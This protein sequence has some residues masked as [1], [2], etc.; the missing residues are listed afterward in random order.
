[1]FNAESRDPARE[2]IADFQMRRTS[3]MGPSRGAGPRE[4]GA[5]LD[6]L[7][8]A[9]RD[10]R[11]LPWRFDLSGVRLTEAHLERLRP[12]FW[13]L[14]DSGISGVVRYQLEVLYVVAG[15]RC[16]AARRFLREVIDAQPRP[17]DKASKRRRTA[18]VAAIAALADET[19]DA[20]MF[21]ELLGL[22]EHPRDEVR[23]AAARGL[24]TLAMEEGRGVPV[25]IVAPVLRRAV[26]A[27]KK[28]AVRFQA[29]AALEMMGAEGAAAPADTAYELEVRLAGDRE[30]TVRLAAPA[31]ASFDALLDAIV[32]AYG[33]ESDH[34]HIWYAGAKSTPDVAMAPHPAMELVDAVPSPRPG[35]LRLRKGD[36][37]MANFD[38]GDN[39]WFAVR[40][41]KVLAGTPAPAG[42]VREIGREGEPPA[43]YPSWDDDDFGWEYESGD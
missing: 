19:G 10:G 5:W 23:A 3:G 9:L 40:V 36:R 13:K 21:E 6:G 14:I 22:L 12:L 16:P 7:K 24:G 42:D 18:A 34:L 29:A 25:D 35:D 8:R 31:T 39:H 37:L 32:G 41:V 33:W 2:W 30:F 17:R 38:F 26:E 1:M 28:L 15:S 11:D 43:Q 20:A 27:D 4:V